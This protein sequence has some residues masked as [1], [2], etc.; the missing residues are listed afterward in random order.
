MFDLASDHQSVDWKPKAD[1]F[2]PEW[3]EAGDVTETITGDLHTY[4]YEVLVTGVIHRD[5]TTHLIPE[6]QLPVLLPLDVEN[7]K[8]AG[9]SPLADHPHFPYYQVGDMLYM[10]E[11]DTL[12]T[13]VDSSFYFLR[14]PDVDNTEDLCSR[15][16]R[17]VMFPVDMY[18]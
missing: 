8:P 7:Y 13:F 5:R 12:D 11:C 10:R 6:E 17:E 16:L 1:R 9:V 3:I 18:V 14:Y 2:V 4:V 15:R